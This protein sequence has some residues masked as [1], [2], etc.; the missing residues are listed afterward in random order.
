MLHVLLKYCLI[1]VT[2]FHDIDDTVRYARY[3]TI[4]SDRR[5]DTIRYDIEAGHRRYDT[6]RYVAGAPTIRYDTIILLAISDIGISYGIVDTM[7]NR[8]S[9]Q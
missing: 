5:D 4:L 2:I 8:A 9:S 6:I 3:D 7:A 1:I